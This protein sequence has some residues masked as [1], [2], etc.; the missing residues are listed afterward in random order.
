MAEPSPALDVVV[1]DDPGR[2]RYEVLVDGELAG[3]A[4]YHVQPGLVTVLHTEI[5]P[6]FEGQGLGSRLAKGA[7]DDARGRDVQ[8][9]PRCSFINNY[10]KRHPEYE[11]LTAARD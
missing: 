3:Y 9:V 4:D 5:D 8:V 7:L 10:I 6:A 2:S 1:R 11:D